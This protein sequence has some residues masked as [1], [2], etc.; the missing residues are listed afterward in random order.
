MS[1]RR[2]ILIVLL[3]AL[4]SGVWWAR[5]D[6]AHYSDAYVADQS[7][8]LWSATAQ[9]RRQVG[10]LGYGEK[11]SVLAR[12]GELTEVRSTDGTQGWVD[13]RLLMAPALW[14]QVGDLVSS[15]QKMPVQ[16]KGHTRTI[17]N[18]HIEPGRDSSRIFQ[19]GRNVPVVVLRRQVAA[20]SHAASDDR[21]SDDSAPS[22]GEKSDLEDW[23]FILYSPVKSGSSSSSAGTQL[24]NGPAIQVAGWVLSRFVELDPPQPIGDYT[25]ASGRRVVGWVEL[26]TI[27]DPSGDK[28]QYAVAA[29]KT[30]EGQLC[31]FT[32]IRVYTWGAVRMRYET[33]FA[34]NSVCGRLPVRV[35]QTPSGPEFRFSDDKSVERA[36]RLMGTV[37]RRLTPAGT[38]RKRQK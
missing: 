2:W 29:A 18:V 10:T 33:S 25:A 8:T 4:I 31:D 26:N 23:S 11:V 15:A 24:N 19:F 38:V 5:R 28:S 12:A 7:A 3:V 1:P 37:V 6:R 14:N 36:Y 16:A 34:D 32:S 17:S 22:A 9:V 13:T 27:H 30:G 21:T 20:A 35:S